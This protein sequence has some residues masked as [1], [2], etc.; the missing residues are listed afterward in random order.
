MKGI[1]F[2]AV[3]ALTAVSLNQPVAAQGQPKHCDLGNSVEH[4]VYRSRREIGGNWRWR[5]TPVNFTGSSSQ[6]K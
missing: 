5:S 1:V 6:I 2:F 4:I 3:A